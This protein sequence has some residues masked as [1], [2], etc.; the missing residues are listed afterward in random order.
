MA[1]IGILGHPDARLANF[2]LGKPATSPV[3]PVTARARTRARHQGAVS[4]LVT[5][6]ARG[7]TA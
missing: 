6:S 4:S 3:N 7:R 1:T 2:A 5:A